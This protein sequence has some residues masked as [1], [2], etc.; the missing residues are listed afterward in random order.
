MLEHIRRGIK[1]DF[2]ILF[3]NKSDK[4]NCWINA[5]LGFVRII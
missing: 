3:M 5:G 2:L 1:A 4:Y